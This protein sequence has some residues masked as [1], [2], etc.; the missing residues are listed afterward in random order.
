MEVAILIEPGS[1]QNEL[2]ALLTLITVQKEQ[3]LLWCTYTFFLSSEINCS[4]IKI[5]RISS[6]YFAMDNKIINICIYFP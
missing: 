3:S 5:I 6:T 2:T 4:E 1:L